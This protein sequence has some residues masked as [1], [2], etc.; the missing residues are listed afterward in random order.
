MPT[1]RSRPVWAVV[2]A[3]GQGRRLGGVCKALLQAHGHTLIERQLRAMF[4]A[5]VERC[6]VVTG[7]QASAVNAEVQRFPELMDRTHIVYAMNTDKAEPADIQQSVQRGLLALRNMPE[8]HQCSVLLSLVDLPLLE[9]EQITALLTFARLAKAAIALPESPTAQPGHPLFLSPLV[10]QSLDLQAPNFS[11][12]QWLHE[13][14]H[15]FDLQRM[16]SADPGYFVDVDTPQ[17]LAELA[18]RYRLPLSIP[19]H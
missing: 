6:I 15:G 5:G 12:R 13:E 7:F 14:R 10:L 3:A 11:L 18:S 9:S 16:G 2:L 17:D 1:P 8:A 4:Q 19:D